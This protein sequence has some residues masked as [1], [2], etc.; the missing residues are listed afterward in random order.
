MLSK[1]KEDITNYKHELFFYITLIRHYC[2]SSNIK[3]NIIISYHERRM[4]KR[5]YKKMQSFVIIMCQY[6]TCNLIVTYH[7]NLTFIVNYL[8]T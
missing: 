4:L 5:L 7:C 8:I 1:L 6:E 2:Y 3:I